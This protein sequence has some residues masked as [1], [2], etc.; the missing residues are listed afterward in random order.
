MEY[1]IF[2]LQSNYLTGPIEGKLKA[3]LCFHIL[4]TIPWQGS[5]ELSNLTP[6][7]TNSAQV[8]Q[9]EDLAFI[10]DDKNIRVANNRSS[11]GIRD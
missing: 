5:F 10:L 2:S 9:D 4:H 1:L 6:T 11:V 3:Q 7:F 8:R